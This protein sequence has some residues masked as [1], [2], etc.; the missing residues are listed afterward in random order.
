MV[1]VWRLGVCLSVSHS[2]SHAFA[3]WPQE[4]VVQR[5]PNS[6]KPRKRFRIAGPM[7][8]NAGILV[9][10]S[11]C[12]VSW[13]QFLCLFFTHSLTPRICTPNSG[14]PR[15]P[16]EVSVRWAHKC[17]GWHHGVGL[18]VWRF[19]LSL[20]VFI[21]F[22]FLRSLGP[23]I[24]IARPRT[25][26]ST[27]GDFGPTSANPGV[28]VSVSVMASVTL[29][30]CFSHCGGSHSSD[31][32]QARG[33]QTPGPDGDSMTPHD[34]KTSRPVLL[35]PWHPDSK[36]GFAD[37]VDQRGGERERA[38][39]F[40]PPDRATACASLAA[41]AVGATPA[42]AGALVGG[43]LAVIGALL[44]LQSPFAALTALCCRCRWSHGRLC[45]CP[46][47]RQ[48]CLPCRPHGRRAFRC[49]QLRPK[50]F[51][52]LH[53]VSGAPGPAA[54]DDV[55]AASTDDVVAQCQWQRR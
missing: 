50:H 7:S 53:D 28:L 29:W 9:S 12:P 49:G 36:T 23:R 32:L 54:T 52:L 41:A 51:G 38:A 33:T 20:S 42:F 4:S 18:G 37:V 46:L 47:S 26:E 16:G 17:K 2:L 45:C 15:A 3:L 8:A 55:V 24:C 40:G 13:R 31:M 14:K 19:G 27:G 25:P 10:V 34:S 6:G 21:C 30:L 48:Q 1:S 11:W 22:S 39:R 43:V 5:A 44:A 35:I